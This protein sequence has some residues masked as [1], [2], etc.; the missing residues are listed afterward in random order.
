MA[1]GRTVALPEASDR[2]IELGHFRSLA[3]DV[4]GV[5]ARNENLSSLR[6]PIPFAT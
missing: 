1:Q 4:L 6:R 3:T 2:G 5:T